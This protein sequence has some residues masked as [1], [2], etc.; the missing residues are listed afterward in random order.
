M[1]GSSCFARATRW[2]TAVGTASRIA[3]SCAARLSIAGRRQLDG[4]ELHA[5]RVAARSRQNRTSGVSGASPSSARPISSNACAALVLGRQI[6]RDEQRELRAVE[7]R[8]QLDAVRPV[9]A[10]DLQR[11]RDP[12][13][14]WPRHPGRAGRPMPRSAVRA[15]AAR[16]R[17]RGAAAPSVHG[18]SARHCAGRRDSTRS[19]ADVTTPSVP[20]APMKRSI[21]VHARRREVAGRQL[22]AATASGRSARARRTVPR[23]S[24]EVEVPVRCARVAPRSMSRTSPSGSTTVS[25]STQSR[26]VPCLNVAAPAALVATTPPTNAPVKVGTGRIGQA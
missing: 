4:I 14:R 19:V 9:L 22:R 20:S 24:V 5:R 26:V 15:G 17:A 11:P 2:F 18:T 23:D 16:P 21:E 13:A 6:E 25:A 1:R 8:W 12:C 3:S 10:H 7:R